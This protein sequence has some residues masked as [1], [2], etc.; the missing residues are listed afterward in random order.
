M[1]EGGISW[2]SNSSKKGVQD[3]YKCKLCGR[4][5]K[6]AWALENHMNQHKNE[7]AKG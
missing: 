5:Y 2:N 7:T 1:K 4:T 6:M 3:R